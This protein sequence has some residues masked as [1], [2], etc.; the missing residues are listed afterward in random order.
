MSGMYAKDTVVS[1]EK[2]RAEIESTL[3]RYGA[4]R[5]A[6]M[7]EP[8]RAIIGFQI[9]DPQSKVTL[10]VRMTLPLPIKGDRRFTHRKVYSRVVENPPEM[11]NKLWEQACR[12]S[13]R[14]LCLVIKAKL[15]ACA[16]GIS[17]VERE[18]MAD[19]V[20]PDGKTIGEHMSP[21]LAAMS[22]RG[23]VPRLMLTA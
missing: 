18:F 5:F 15:E 14:S 17:T 10:M 4:D 12:S 13:W 21:Q 7:T 16:A 9:A 2:S 6:Y 3:A 1:V 23:E 22:E 19:V 11:V 8:G 20:T